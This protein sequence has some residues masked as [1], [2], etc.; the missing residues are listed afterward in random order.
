MKK[1]ALTREDIKLVRDINRLL[2]KLILDYYEEFIKCDHTYKFLDWTFIDN[3]NEIRITYSFV[4]CYCEICYDSTIV[5]IDELNG[6]IDTSESEKI[7]N[8]Y[9]NKGD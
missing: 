5:T 6:N 8:F 4:D 7:L 9:K 1:F 2:D 3:D